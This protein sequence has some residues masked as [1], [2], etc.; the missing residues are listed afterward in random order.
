MVIDIIA[1]IID[2]AL[3][4]GGGLS[5]PAMAVLFTVGGILS[6]YFTGIRGKAL[7]KSFRLYRQEDNHSGCLNG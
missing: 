3:D 4:L 1:I 6:G 7:L 5:L 2:F